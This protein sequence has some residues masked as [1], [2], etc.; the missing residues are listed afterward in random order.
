MD[1]L[2]DGKKMDRNYKGIQVQVLVGFVA[3]PL[4]TDRYN[5][6]SGTLSEN[7]LVLCWPV[8]TLI[9][10]WV[11]NDSTWSQMNDF[12]LQGQRHEVC[13]LWSVGQRV[14]KLIGVNYFVD[15]VALTN[16]ILNISCVKSLSIHWFRTFK[17]KGQP[18]NWSRFHIGKTGRLGQTWLESLFSI[19]V[20]QPTDLLCLF[21]VSGC[22]WTCTEYHYLASV[23]S[24]IWFFK[25]TWSSHALTDY[26]IKW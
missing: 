19:R 16:A 8:V 10:P 1:K 3:I 25:S 22:N 17:S 15:P 6:M 23:V 14:T 26:L 12:P 4:V 20:F 18:L 2:S 13:S 11:E 7:S 24:L 9:S 21:C 5:W